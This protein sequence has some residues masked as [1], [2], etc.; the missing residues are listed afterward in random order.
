MVTLDLA[1][2]LD[3]RPTAT[4][5]DGRRAV[6]RRRADRRLEPR[7]PGACGSSAARA[8]VHVDKAHPRRRRAR[9]RLG[10][11]RRRAA[12]GRRATTSAWP[13]RW[14]PTCRSASSAAGRGSAA[15]AR[16]S[17]R[18]RRSTAPSRWSRRRSPCRR[19][20]STGPGTSWAVRPADGPTTSS[21]RPW[22][23]PRAGPV[24]RPHP[25]RR[26]RAAHAGGQRGDLV[27]RRCPP[28]P[29]RRAARRIGRRDAHRPP[30]ASSGRSVGESVQLVTCCDAGGAYGEASSCASSSACACGAS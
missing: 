1:D 19:R 14:A 30:V 9:R 4:A 10:R 24:A 28:G 27:R 2:T 3:L 29:G 21:P 17:S 23:W 7:A 15:S 5:L 6:R 20:P 8:A 16:W 22:S 26:R 18:C 25:G 11:R 12:L 13:P